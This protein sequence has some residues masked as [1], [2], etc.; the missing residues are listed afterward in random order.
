[1]IKEDM[2]AMLNDRQYPLR[3]T[4]EEKRAAEDSKLIIAYGESDDLLEVEGHWNDEFSAYEGATIFIDHDGSVPHNKCDNPDCPYFRDI[5]KTIPNW[6]KAEWDTDGY[7]WV[8]TSNLPYAP[9]DIVEGDDKF[10]RGI[11]IQI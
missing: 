6:I 8:I 9:F 7:S 3:I 11:V 5:A 4:K 1:M 2:A 10:C